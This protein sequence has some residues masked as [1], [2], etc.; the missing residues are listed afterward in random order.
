MSGRGRFGRRLLALSLAVAG[1]ALAELLLR[2]VGF[3]YWPAGPIVVWNADEDAEMLGAGALH[4]IDA[5]TLWSPRPGASIPWGEGERVSPGGYRGADPDPRA[6]V[7]VVALGDS[8]T[9]GYGVAAGETWAARLE[10]GLERELEL[11]AADVQVLDAGLI[12]G[13]IVQGLERYRA[14]PAAWRPSVAVLAFGAVNEHWP[15]GGLDDRAKLARLRALAEEGRTPGG[16]LA[17]L[18]SSSRLLHAAA[19]LADLLRGGRR[20]IL[21]ER[22]SAGASAA[23]ARRVRYLEPGYQ[24]RVSPGDFRATL[25]AFR[26]EAQADGT[27]LV[28][29]HVPRTRE[30]EER[31]PAVLD[32]DPVLEAFAAETGT[33]LVEARADFRAAPLAENAL[34]VD[35]YHPTARGHARIA[36]LLLPVVA[37]ILRGELQR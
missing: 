15:S 6:R 7:R 10:V 18:R 8:S 21:A 1:L 17:R 3:A 22:A 35:A 20:A 28:L 13:T 29:L 31:R 27:R 12:G 14:L 16:R 9:F 4:E 2:L 36:A 37:D 25:E 32:Y 11:P 5:R 19:W 34:F 33:P 26:A 30:T 24:R 23:G